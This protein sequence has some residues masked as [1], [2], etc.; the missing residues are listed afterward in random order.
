MHFQCKKKLCGW[1]S[2]LV[3]M[4]SVG[5][6]NFGGPSGV[7][8][9]LS[10]AVQSTVLCSAANARFTWSEEKKLVDRKVITDM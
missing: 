6:S 4:P 2:L 3:L 8:E 7:S 1:R 5:G 9:L 10:R